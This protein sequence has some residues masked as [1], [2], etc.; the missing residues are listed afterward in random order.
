[1]KFWSLPSATGT[2]VP[3][4]GV[5]ALSHNTQLQRAVISNRWRGASA[6]FHC[7]LVPVLDMWSRGR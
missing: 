1:M 3:A 6:S 2:G 4:S 5:R 7:A